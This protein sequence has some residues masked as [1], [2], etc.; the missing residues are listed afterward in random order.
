VIPRI[1]NDVVGLFEAVAGGSLKDVEINTDPRTAVTVMLVSGGYPG[2]YEKE[3]SIHGLATENDS[4]VFH[5][6]TIQHEGGII[7]SGGRVLAVTSF[8]QSIP[9]ACDKSYETISNIR[10]EGMYY[11]KDIGKDLATMVKE[12]G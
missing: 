11:R 9:E 1:Q 6:G 5:A 7:S 12:V 4:L 2:N 10:F 3:K 8:G